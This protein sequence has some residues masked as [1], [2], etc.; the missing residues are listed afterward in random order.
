MTILLEK[1]LWEVR[2][3]CLFKHAIGIYHI[4]QEFP[5][6]PN[7]NV[8]FSLSS[9]HFH[10]STKSEM[11]QVSFDLPVMLLQIFKLDFLG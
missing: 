4:Y 8:R 2:L 5:A 3:N 11:K 6:V 10:K 9:K 7:K 1:V